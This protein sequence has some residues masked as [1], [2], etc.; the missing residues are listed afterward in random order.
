[1]KG[2]NKDLKMF[3]NR[4]INA[5]QATSVKLQQVIR[6]QLGDEVSLNKFDG[7]LPSTNFVTVRNA[8]VLMEV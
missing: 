6:G 3:T 8:E 1:M 7:Y 4:N 5:H 2:F